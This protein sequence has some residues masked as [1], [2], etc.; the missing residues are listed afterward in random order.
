[1]TDPVEP[2]CSDLGWLLT[3]AS[4]SLTTQLTAAME[5]IG[6]TPRGNCV[7]TAAMGGEF[8][9]IELA[10]AIGLDKTTMVVTVDTLE[11][12][13]LA[14]RRPSSTDR[15]AHVI[16]VTKAGERKVREAREVARRVQDEVLAT[17]PQ[18]QR[19]VLM[20]AL[21]ALVSGSLAEPVQCTKRVRRPAAA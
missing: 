19:D 7:L 12:A 18:R 2:L 1:M 20:P 9:Q 17:L 14:E 6:L 13:G 16:T 5:E 10:K 8:T 3:R 21:Q 4:H 11:R 15:R